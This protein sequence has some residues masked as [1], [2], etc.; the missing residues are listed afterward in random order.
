MDESLKD[1]GNT[2]VYKRILSFGKK[3]KELAEYKQ[4]KQ[5]NTEPAKLLILNLNKFIAHWTW[6]YQE[7][8]IKNSHKY[9][10][11][12]RYN[13]R[14]YTTISVMEGLLRS[15][16]HY[17]ETEWIQLLTQINHTIT[18]A[19]Q[20]YDS[21][22]LEFSLFPV[23]YAI[24]QI[25]RYLKTNELS[26]RLH[27]FMCDMLTWEYFVPS[28]ND[29]GTDI[30]KS[31]KKIQQIVNTSHQLTKYS[32]VSRDQFAKELNTMIQV[33]Q[34][35][36]NTTFHQLLYLADGASTGKPS[37]AFN[38]ECN[39]LI[40]DIDKNTYRHFAQ[41]VV[42]LALDT[43][44]VISQDEGDD[45]C[46]YEYLENPSKQFLKGIVWS[47]A[48]FSDKTSIHLLEKLLKKGTTKV[49][50]WGAVAMALT[51]ACVHTLG[52]MRGKDALG[53][54]SCAKLSV[55]QNNVKKLIDKQLDTGAKK[56]GVS[57]AE[58]EEMAVPDFGLCA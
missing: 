45:Y 16:L 51:N 50:G 2:E 40:I 33:H 46:T 6:Q 24:Q 14:L 21:S 55:S 11:Y 13:K 56:Y 57:V 54:L 18:D 35:T 38:E 32:L 20:H 15:K 58:L 8:W 47:M 34:C 52:E 29:W 17:T 26:D 23:N 19:N 4:I 39:T 9:E 22:D 10:G 3:Y 53:A 30:N 44:I 12:S 42:Q 36:D 31:R 25:E 5:G 41:Q 1:F 43:S 27:A 49:A 37:S 48:V 7:K 28:H